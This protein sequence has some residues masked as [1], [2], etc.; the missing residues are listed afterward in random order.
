VIPE[1]AWAFATGL[2]GSLHCLGMCGPLVIA[3]SLH[4]KPEGSVISGAT[5][6]RPWPERIAHHLWFHLGRIA[7]YCLLG[8]LAAGLIHLGDIHGSL[9]GLRTGATLA[10]GVLMVLLGLALLKAVP[11]RFTSPAS[12]GENSTALSR[13]M[14][15]LLASP[16]SRSRIM[17][18][19]FAGFLPCMFSWAMIV[20]AATTGNP[21][22]GFLLMT[23][24]GLGTLP[25][26][27][28][29]GFAAS[30]FSFRVRLAGERTGA[31]SVI[32]MG[33]ILL[34]KGTAHLV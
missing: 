33:L 27:F 23:L 26:L 3:Y 19:F 32:V 1:L 8:V 25:A 12:S 29:T 6:A 31:I 22:T 13:I 21:W 4:L 18:G 14:A 15:T 5:S 2:A 17:L 11:F 9:K 28:F 30:A 34:F 24:F 16:G 20:K 7:A 10:G